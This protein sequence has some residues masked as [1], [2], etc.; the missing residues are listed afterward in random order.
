MK[1]E[2]S[3]RYRGYVI[4]RSHFYVRQFKWSYVHNNYDNVPDVNNFRGG[5]EKTIEE[6]I[7][8]ID[9]LEGDE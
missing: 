1:E 6:V 8:V 3:I 5:S 2:H 9:E 7:D 4:E